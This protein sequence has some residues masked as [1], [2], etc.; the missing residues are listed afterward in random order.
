MC[1]RGAATMLPLVTSEKVKPLNWFHEG[2]IAVGARLTGII[3]L[4]VGHR[5]ESATIAK[6]TSEERHG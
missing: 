4:T 1:R 5:L 6:S 2:Y 3:S